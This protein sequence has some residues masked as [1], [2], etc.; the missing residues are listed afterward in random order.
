MLL[1]MR[2]SH[3]RV[4]ARSDLASGTDHRSTE[5]LHHRIGDVID[6]F[7]MF[8][9][10]G[11][12]AGSS[13]S[14]V[15]A[16]AAPLVQGLQHYNSAVRCDQLASCPKGIQQPRE[17]HQACTCCCLARYESPCSTHTRPSQR[18]CSLPS[19]FVVGI[20]A[21][22]IFS[23]LHDR[24]SVR[25]LPGELVSSVARRSHSES[26]GVMIQRHY[27]ADPLLLCPPPQGSLMSQCV[28]RV[29]AR[30]VCHHG[31]HLQCRPRDET[32]SVNTAT[33]PNVGNISCGGRSSGRC[34]QCGRLQHQL[35]GV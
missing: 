20:L 33:C 15:A 17:T 22:T 16:P 29:A 23:E 5:L 2:A 19:F 7:S 4:R 6:V 32:E 14:T 31:I 11:S 21:Q 24:C 13:A 30:S 18:W 27:A 1:G 10:G 26:H 9:C 35:E 34:A 3:A 25:A 12:A 8:D 28:E